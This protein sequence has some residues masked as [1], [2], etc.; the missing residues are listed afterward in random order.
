MDSGCQTDKSSASPN[1]TST[2]QPSPHKGLTLDEV[3]GKKDHL[4]SGNALRLLTPLSRKACLIHGIDPRSLFDRDFASFASPGLDPEIQ[5]MQYE[6][7]TRTREKLFITASDERSALA[8]STAANNDSFTA[9]T[10]GDSVSLVSRNTAASPGDADKIST[11]IA[12]EK[13]RLDKVAR[14]QKK[15]LLR[16]LAF[17]TKSKE[18]MD[19]MRARTEEMERIEE[20]RK[21]ER[22]KQDAQRA[23]EARVK[24]LRKAAIAEAQEAIAQR[25]MNEQYERERKMH[26]QKLLHEKEAKRKARE[27]EVQ[28]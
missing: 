1:A 13:Q 24:A 2:Q 19:K 8:R 22:R 18:I 5:A 4:P 9:T 26:E 10:C 17:E 3:F 27:E 25:N 14:R 28:R 21:R 20:Q 16:M 6:A 15:E 23:E 11:L 12:R 7:Y